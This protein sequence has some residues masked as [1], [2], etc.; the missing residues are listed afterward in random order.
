MRILVIGSNVPGGRHTVR[1]APIVLRQA[2]AGFELRGH[3]L[4]FQL[5]LEPERSARL[6]GEEE[7]DLDE[8]RAAGVDVLEPMSSFDAI[9]A[10]SRRLGARLRRELAPAAVDFVPSAVLADDMARR[11]ERSAADVVFHLWSPTALAACR[12]SPTPTY[13]YYGNPDHKPVEAR[14]RH[15]ELFDDVPQGVA[16]RARSLRQNRIRRRIHLDLMRTA[17]WSGNVCAV[18]AAFYAEQG[19]PDA[20]YVQN[21]WVDYGGP[22][23][24]TRK[25]EHERGDD[26]FLGGLGGLYATG[27]TFGLHFLASEIVPELQSR[28]GDRFAVDVAGA[29]QPSRNLARALAHPRIA[30]RGFV[31]DADAEIRG[32]KIFLI[33]NNCRDEFVV[34]H[35]RILHAWSLGACV[36]GHVNTALAMPELMSGVNCLLGST[37]GEIADHVEAALGDEELRRRIGRGGRRAFER[38]FL[39]EVVADRIVDRIEST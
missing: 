27:N 16:A 11:I 26:R 39:P 34:G 36:I 6:D 21:M 10:P 19:H 25:V 5:L 9:H 31:D 37:A 17:R 12:T 32:S 13:A 14:L 7:R 29:G 3:D 1:A 35:T 28:L 18:D 20:F 22:D 4:A 24:E 33:A 2:L 8:L 38:E 30:L 23:W 15:P